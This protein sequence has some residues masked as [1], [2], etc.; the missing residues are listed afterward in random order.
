MGGIGAEKPG[1]PPLWVHRLLAIT[2]SYAGASE[3]SEVASAEAFL[4]HLAADAEL[5]QVPP[6]MRVLMLGMIADAFSQRHA[7]TGEIPALDSA[8]AVGLRWVIHAH[9]TMGPNSPGT[10]AALAAVGHYLWVRGDTRNDARDLDAAIAML[11][12]ALA[13]KTVSSD[14]LVQLLIDLGLALRARHS[15]QTPGDPDRSIA[16]LQAAADEALTSTADHLACLLN[17]GVVLRERS[18]ING[19]PHDAD[20][21]LGLHEHVVRATPPDSPR[22]AGRQHELLSTLDVHFK[23]TGQPADLDRMTE[24][25]QTLADA[26]PPPAKY[27]YLAKLASVLDDKLTYFGASLSALLQSIEILEGIVAATPAEDPARPDRLGQLSMALH[28]LAERTGDL[29]LTD[30][31]V[32]LATEAITM[33]S[34]S[35]AAWAAAAR[36][37]AVILRGRAEITGSHDDIDESVRLLERIRRP[38]EGTPNAYVPS[39]SLGNTL[40]ARYRQCHA[41]EDLD[42]AVTVLE[43]S[44]SSTEPRTPQRMVA[45]RSLTNALYVRHS[46]TRDERDLD[47]LSLISR[48]REKIRGETT[49]EYED[50]GRLLDRYERMN[51]LDDLD[52]AI[53]MLETS[54]ASEDAPDVGPDE[55]NDRTVNFGLALWRRYGASGDPSGP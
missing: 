26:L 50:V 52:Q 35:S 11:D 41:A 42:R 6:P 31:A 22:L 5:S 4:K 53:A 54:L 47:R 9:A 20:R 24:V 8:I 51:D 34:P 45:L 18:T 37:L 19:D 12:E 25:L 36:D 10:G 21:A 29:A 27:A 13:T 2:A 49:P 46:V 48:E 16:I 33:T 3:Q 43:E 7:N 17:L 14:Q 44:V 28:K 39:L 15:R 40:L 38:A 55:K 1:D 30:R 23:A 32:D